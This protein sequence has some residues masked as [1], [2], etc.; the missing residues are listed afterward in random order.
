MPTK[1]CGFKGPLVLFP[2]CLDM[3]QRSKEKF[4]KKKI[5]LDSGKWV[6]SVIFSASIFGST[7]P[8]S[9][10]PVVLE[11]LAAGQI[12]SQSNGATSCPLGFQNNGLL[13]TMLWHHYQ[14]LVTTGP[15][16]DK[17]H[18]LKLLILLPYINVFHLANCAVSASTYDRQCLMGALKGREAAVK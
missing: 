9:S 4:G 10:S 11:S 14:L 13:R 15:S 1:A 18:C 12:G 8:W 3:Q 5:L 7:S 6:Q 16:K 17:V 2:V